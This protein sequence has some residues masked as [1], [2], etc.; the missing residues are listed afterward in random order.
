MTISLTGPEDS[1]APL[2]QIDIG[3]GAVAAC[4]GKSLPDAYRLARF[5]TEEGRTHL[6]LQ[7]Y[8]TWTQGCMR[9]LCGE[10]RDIETVDADA[11]DDEPYGPLL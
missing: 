8:F 7:G 11:S 3:A 1:Q 6:K 2:K 4:C 9:A 10:W 5:Q